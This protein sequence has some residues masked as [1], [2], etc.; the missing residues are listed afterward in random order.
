MVKLITTSVAL[1]ILL[2]A[3][4]LSIPF[5][6]TDIYDVPDLPARGL[7]DWKDTLSADT[8]RRLGLAVQSLG[9]EGASAGAF[10]NDTMMR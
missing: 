9:D 3:D 6:T 5:D 8:R 7:D 2:V 1:A 4:A 10:R